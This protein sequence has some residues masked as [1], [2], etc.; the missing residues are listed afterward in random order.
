MVPTGPDNELNFF[1]SPG[2]QAAWIRDALRIMRHW[3]RI[4]ALGWQ[5]VYDDPPA[6]H[7]TASGLLNWQGLPK[8]G[9]FAYK[10]G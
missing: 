1:V 8:P 6:D 4:Y 5:H 10:H 3:N 2:A 9:Y 7:G